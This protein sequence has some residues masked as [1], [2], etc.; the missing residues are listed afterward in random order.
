M[1]FVSNFNMTLAASGMLEA[2][3]KYQYLCT[4]VR[5]E[6]LFQFDLLSADV[7]VTE[8]LNVDYIIRGLS[9]YFPH[10][11][12]MSKQNRAMRLGMEKPRSQTVTCYAA[13]LINLNE[14]L[15]SLPG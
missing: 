4:I 2:G 9:Q 11:N 8:N 10:V 15:V 5:E 3:A 12:S 1:L 7:E 14:Y 6:V 13:H